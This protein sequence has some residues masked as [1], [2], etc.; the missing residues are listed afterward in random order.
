MLQE[1]HIKERQNVRRRRIKRRTPAIHT[2]RCWPRVP[3]PFDGEALHNRMYVNRR[4]IRDAQI[5]ILVRMR[6]H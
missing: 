3:K 5:G 6:D 4:A 2:R 1:V